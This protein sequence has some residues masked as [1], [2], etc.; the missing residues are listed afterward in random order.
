[1][2][3]RILGAGPAGRGS[4]RIADDDEKACRT[5]PRSRMCGSDE[6]ETHCVSLIKDVG[7]DP[8]HA[9]PLKK[10]NGR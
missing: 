2:K 5:Q 9:R 3:D 7:P 4:C 10:M 8:W 6:F 1:V